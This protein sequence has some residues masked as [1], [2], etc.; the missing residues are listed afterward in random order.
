M[1]RRF[2]RNLIVVSLAFYVVVVAL[3]SY[4]GL[5]PAEGSRQA[6]AAI[7]SG[8][9]AS[10]L[11]ALGIRTP[12]PFT[13]GRAAA[14][15]NPIP[16]DTPFSSSPP[17]ALPSGTVPRLVLPASVINV[18]LLGTD[19]RDA[20]QSNWRTDTII[21][22]SIDQD[23]KTV[24][25][26]SIPRDLWVHIPGF[27]D[28]RINTA[29]FYGE[30]NH[31][32]GGGPQTVKSTLE[33]NLGFRVH[34]YVRVGFDSFRKAID[35]LG[36]IDM[37]VDC[38]VVET[39]FNDDYGVVN[40]NFQPGLQHMDGVTALRYARSRYSTS[41]YDRSRR[42]RQVL[43]AIWDRALSLDLL[44]RWPDLYRQFS[45]SIQTDLGPAELASLG[46]TGSQL[47]MDRIRS[48]AIDNRTTAPWTTPAGEE[49]LLPQPDK[50]HTL[51]VDFFTPSAQGNDPFEAEQARVQVVSENGETANS[52]AVSLR[53][54][55][56]Q[57]GDPRSVSS[58]VSASY[59]NVFQ[60]KPITIQRLL[61][62]LRINPANVRRVSDPKAEI[63]VQVILSRDYNPCQK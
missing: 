44:P 45:S 53:R 1:N 50:I 5:I 47:K 3:I 61:T 57:V 41:D 43:L 25:L 14:P 10:P 19:K 35:T 30:Y 34:Y 33:Q 18:I 52:V 23:R 20:G 6:A 21:L 32:P 60:D 27:G 31:L 24:G 55:G 37:N 12:T 56:F 49:V 58:P 63:D 28:Q 4:F 22:V 29:D 59:I 39:G 7:S 36:G 51:L 40:L 46:F 38:P 11:V 15:L 17:S 8:Y 48:R 2:L 62:A 9:S 16:I 54:Q 42:Q 13:A 26:L